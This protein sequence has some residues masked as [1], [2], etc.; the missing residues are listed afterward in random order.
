MELKGLKTDFLGKNIIFFP[1]LDST[2]KKI[3]SLK[4]PENG[5]VVIT[6]KQI[7]G[8]GTHERKWYTGNGD[9]IAVSFVLRPN[10][11]LEK[12][13][14]ITIQTAECLIKTLK[15]I[16]N[17][18]FEIKLPNDIFYQGKK[19]AGILTQTVCKGEI[20][21]KIYIGIGMNVNQDKF[22]GNLSEIAT[23]LKIITGKEFSRER[24][25]VKFFNEFE[26]IYEKMLNEF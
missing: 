6:D 18:Q 9:N 7:A 20:V 15:Y 19:V 22:P 24:I 5:T 3:K 13:E 25:L 26:K 10:C 4:Q 23:S 11:K 12:M 8:V 16:S 14:T 17:Q 1:T 2:Q 21:R